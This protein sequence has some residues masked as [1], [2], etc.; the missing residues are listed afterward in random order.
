MFFE[1]NYKGF[2]ES[3]RINFQGQPSP[4]RYFLG[5]SFYRKAKA[6]GK[7]SKEI[8]LE[9]KIN[10]LEF[11]MIRIANVVYMLLKRKYIK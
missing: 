9:L 3:C 7:N 1:N 8:V 2:C 10:K 6:I 5:A 4:Y 11:W